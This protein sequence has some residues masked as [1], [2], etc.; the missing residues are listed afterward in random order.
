VAQQELSEIPFPALIE[1]SEYLVAL[2]HSAGTATQTGMGLVPLQWVELRAWTETLG[3]Q[4]TAWELETIRRMS[5]AYASEFS[6][7][8]DKKRPIP[9]KPV[10]EI[11]INRVAVASQVESVFS[12]L[13]EKR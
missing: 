13:R 3:V 8:S 1:G 12:A 2:L 10:E 11:V 6:Q 9:Y 7:A 5:E 4:H